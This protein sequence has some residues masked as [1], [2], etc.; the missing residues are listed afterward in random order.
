M[1]N[2]TIKQYDKNQDSKLD[3]DESMDFLEE[4]WKIGLRAP[5]LNRTTKEKVQQ[6]EI[7]T[8]T[9]AYEDLF[10]MIDYNQ[11]GFLD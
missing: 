7:T 4:F 10:S 11:T 8:T 3:K 2:L 5:A 1:A 9:K 6:K